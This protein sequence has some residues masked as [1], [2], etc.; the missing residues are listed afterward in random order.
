MRP[1]QA[2][3]PFPRYRETKTVASQHQLTGTAGV[4]LVAAELSK[5]G[6][7][8]SV[9]SRMQGVLTF[10]W[11]TST[12]SACSVQVKTNKSTF[13]F[14]LMGKNAKVTVSPSHFYVFVNLKKDV[15]EY[16]VVP[17]QVVAEKLYVDPAPKGGWDCDSCSYKDAKEFQ[18]RWDLFGSPVAVSWRTSECDQAEAEPR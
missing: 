2:C 6:F 1:P 3:H 4:Y 11:R 18:D 5:H 9:T 13:G 14:W 17:S 12:A 7:V 16:F 15:T 10:S 8:A